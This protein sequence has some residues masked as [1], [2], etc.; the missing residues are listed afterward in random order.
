MKA[1]RDHLNLLYQLMDQEISNYS[2]LIQEMKK[3]SECLRQ[4]STES[5]I[6]IVHSIER[7]TETIRDLRE[8]IQETIGEVLRTEGRGQA[9]KTLSSLCV[10]LPS[11]DRKRI[12]LYQGTLTKFRTWASQVN[13]LNKVFVND[14]LSHLRDLITLLI[15]PGGESPGYIQNGKRGQ[16]APLPY[17]LNREV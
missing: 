7:H 15:Q 8:A 1:L 9:E 4:G 17:S 16:A 3:E 14:I 13:D 11:S 6:H 5:L 12:R 2:L 10:F